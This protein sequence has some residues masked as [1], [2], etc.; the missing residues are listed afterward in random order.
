[1]TSGQSGSIARRAIVAVLLILWTLQ[2]LG[3]AVFAIP[4]RFDGVEAVAMS[5]LAIVLGFLPVAVLVYLFRE[6]QGPPVG[7]PP[8]AADPTGGGKPGA[9]TRTADPIEVGTSTAG[10]PEAIVEPLSE[11]ELEILA[12]VA[13][14]MSNREIAAAETLTVGTVKTHLT[15]SIASSARR[16]GRRPSRGRGSTA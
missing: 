8:Q 10:E 6:R 2:V 1:V 16:R 4:E 7:V 5:I 3:V 11:R 13:R 9:R 14:G 15:T 12:L